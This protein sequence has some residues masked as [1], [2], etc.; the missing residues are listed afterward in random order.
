MS[1]RDCVLCVYVCVCVCVCVSVCVCMWCECVFCV[2]VAV[3]LGQKTI[4]TLYIT[5]VYIT[6]K[7]DHCITSAHAIHVLS[8]MCQN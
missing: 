4:Y 3:V 7:N 5:A 6:F 8:I 1:L 2:I